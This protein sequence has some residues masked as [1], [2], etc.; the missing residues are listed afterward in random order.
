MMEEKE[1]GRKVTML[2][3]E[4]KEERKIRMRINSLIII[5]FNQK[6]RMHNKYS[7]CILLFQQQNVKF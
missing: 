2:V 7:L 3:V 5:V 1:K 4:K 6:R